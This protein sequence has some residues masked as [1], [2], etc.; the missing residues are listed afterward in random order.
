MSN[1]DITYLVGGA[2]G[3]AVLL[4]FGLLVLR[5]AWTSYS[6]VWQ[7]IAAAFLSLYV[8]ATFVGIGIAGGVAVAWF[9]DRIGA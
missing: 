8:L 2:C 4:A 7:R 6:R 3:L 9:W 1:Q 5:P